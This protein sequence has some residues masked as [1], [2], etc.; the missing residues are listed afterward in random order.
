MGGIIVKKDSLISRFLATPQ[1]ERKEKSHG[2]IEP[3]TRP[4]KESYTG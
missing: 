1:K 4:Y 2:N 3:H